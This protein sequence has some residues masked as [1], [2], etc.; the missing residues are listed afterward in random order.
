MAPEH[1][2]L[3]LRLEGTDLL[4]WQDGLLEPQALPAVLATLAEFAD[5]VA[6]P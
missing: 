3:A 6:R 4:T 5:L 2:R 1:R